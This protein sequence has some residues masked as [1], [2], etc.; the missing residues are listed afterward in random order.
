VPSRIRG[1]GPMR[2]LCRSLRHQD[3]AHEVAHPTR[4]ERVT[5]A[6]GGQRSIQLSYGCVR[7]HLADWLDLGNGQTR[8]DLGGGASKAEKAR[9]TCSNRVEYAK[10]AVSAVAR[11]K[12]RACP[13]AARGDV[14]PARKHS[15]RRTDRARARG[16]TTI[17]TPPGTSA[18][19]KP[20]GRSMATRSGLR[21]THG[22]E[23]QAPA[24]GRCEALR[25]S[26]RRAGV[27]VHHKKGL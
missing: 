12:A 25:G 13:G 19:V 9:V 15:P 8:A 20:A 14:W 24:S 18:I 17:S 16:N 21:S 5:F 4:F 7:V 26:A 1:G 2:L 11:V 23:S 3:Q 10:K 6:F 22:S 27:R